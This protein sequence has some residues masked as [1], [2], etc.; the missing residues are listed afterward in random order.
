M[1]AFVAD[2]EWSWWIILYFFFG[3][4]SA[5]SYFVATLIEL[6]G[7]DADRPLARLGY[8]LAFPLIGICGI[9]LTVDLERPERFWHM[10][11][12]SEVVDAALE[13]GWPR[14]GW[15]TM[16]HAPLLKWWSPMSIGA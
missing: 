1:N 8:R 12:Q 9:F 13:Q 15:G 6:F 10:M 4:L 3:G 11:F 14:G 7:Q 5:G 2:P 16:L